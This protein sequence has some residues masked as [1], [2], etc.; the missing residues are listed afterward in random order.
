MKY[1]KDKAAKVFRKYWG[2][3]RLAFWEFYYNSWGGLA[4]AMRR[5]F[6]KRRGEIFTG[7][8]RKN[9]FVKNLVTIGILTKN[10]LDLIK[11]C[12]ESIEKNLSEKRQV[13]ILIGDTGSDEK[14]VWDFYKEARKKW[15]NVK[16]IKFKKYFFSQNYNQLFGRWA[17]GEHLIFLNND[18]LAKPGWIDNLVEPLQDRKI[19]IVGAKLLHKDGT[20]QHAGIEINPP[21]KTGINA[22]CNEA[23][24]L[25][26]ANA[27]AIVP[28]VTFACAAV[29]HDVFNRFLLNEDYREEAQDTDFCFRL[30][31]GGFSALYEPRAE[32]FHFECSSRDWRKG[33]RDRW[34]LK[35]QWG[36]KIEKLAAEK[37]QRKPFDPDE[38]KD[39]ITVIRDDGI[40]DLLMGVSAFSNLRKK[41]PNKKLILAT[42]ERNIEMMAGFGIFDEFIPIPNGQK[43]A[44]LPIPKDSKVFNFIDMEMDVTPVAGTPKKDNKTNRHIIFTRDMELDPKFEP[45]PMP[46]YPEA[47]KNA[48]KLLQDSGVDMNQKFVIFNLISTNP[49]RSWWEPYYPALI[50]AVEEA[51]FTPVITGTKNSAYYK[52]KNVVNLVNKTKTIAEFIEVVKFGKYVI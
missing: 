22:F 46:D 35:K 41:Y 17:K 43:Y 19:G 49:A 13:E 21:T 27:A 16:I 2:L 4:F 38:Y 45:I 29:R 51:G 20:I 23:G 6:K 25:P 10:R 34:L 15:G 32:I 9:D 36:E 31:T 5:H 12:L 42:Y 44:P 11:P 39:S 3:S 40:G 7:Y 52:G 37:T 18:T 47:R 14:K 50:S 30:A 26:E 8:P 1:F 24:D 48:E 33:E 28:A